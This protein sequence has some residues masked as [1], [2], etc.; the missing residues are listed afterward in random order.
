MDG[1]FRRPRGERRGHRLA[2]LIMSMHLN[3]KTEHK[4]SRDTIA[5]AICGEHAPVIGPTESAIVYVAPKY[6]SMLIDDEHWEIREFDIGESLV[7]SISMAFESS[8]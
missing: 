2:L 5:C 3:E 6:P 8:G 1:G 7:F 4:S